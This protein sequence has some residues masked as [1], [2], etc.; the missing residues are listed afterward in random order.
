MRLLNTLATNA[1][2]FEHQA[3]GIH[4]AEQYKLHW[5]NFRQKYN[6]HNEQH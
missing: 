1:L 6:V 2:V 4:G 3:I 5:N